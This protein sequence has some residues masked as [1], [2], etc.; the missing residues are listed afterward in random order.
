[1]SNLSPVTN[2]DTAL[3]LE[4]AAGIDEDPLTYG[5]VLSVVTV[6]RGKKTETLLHRLSSQLGKDLADLLRFMIAGIEFRRDLHGPLR[7]LTLVYM[8]GQ[9]KLCGPPLHIFIS[10]GMTS[11]CS[12]IVSCL[13]NIKYI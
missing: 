7:G 2:R 8:N 5:D 9:A 10:H 13:E 4:M 6:K 11:F 1:M 3:V 12:I